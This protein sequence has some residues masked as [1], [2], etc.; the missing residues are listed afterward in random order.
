[1]LVSNE[2]RGPKISQQKSAKTFWAPNTMN[3][4]FNIASI[5][6]DALSQAVFSFI[7]T[8]FEKF[9]RLISKPCFAA[10][11]ASSVLLKRTS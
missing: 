6:V 11:F 10:C 5:T 7:Y 4:F 9:C 3:L 2:K 8:I 1:M